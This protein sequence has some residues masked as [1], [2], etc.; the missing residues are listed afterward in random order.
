MYSKIIKIKKKEGKRKT[1]EEDK[2][3]EKIQ[4]LFSSKKMN[5]F[6]NTI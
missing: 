5:F 4:Q 3:N 2:K 1:K 6:V